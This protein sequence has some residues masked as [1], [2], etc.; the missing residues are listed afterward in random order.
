MNIDRRPLDRD[1]YRIDS[2]GG[3]PSPCL[4][5][6]QE[7]VESN[8]DLIRKELDSVHPARGIGCLR[9]HVKTHKSS[10]VTRMQL[11]A[12]ID[13]FKCT[14][15]EL[16]MLLDE[17]VDNLFVA[18]PP[19]PPL[20]SRIARAVSENDSLRIFSQ[21][22][23]VEHAIC[24]AAAADERSVE[25]NYL[26]DTDVGDHRTGLPPSEVYALLCA[27]R[28]DVRFTRLRFAGLHAYDGHNHSGDE[29]KRIACARESME[30]LAQVVGALKEGQ[31]PIEKVVVGGTPGF[32]HCLEALVARGDLDSEIEVSPGTFIYWDTCYDEMMPGRFH[33]A[34]LLLARVMDRP[35][36][37]RITLD[38]GHKR[39]G[40]DQGFVHRFSTPGLRVVKVSEEHTVLEHDR[41]CDL[42]IGDWVLIAPRHVCPTVNLW[43]RFFLVDR[44]GL[45]QH[46]ALAVTARNR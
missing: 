7:Q 14:P 22:S 11:A 10:W 36:R 37:N 31:I 6:F 41:S 3:L 29:R 40:I 24:L 16:D 9:P 39:W 32:L 44:T 12:G 15:N 17:G 1:L 43:E 5:V 13:R 8:L 28:E 21:V 23:C 18:Y 27:I 38:I 42:Q 19:L 45:P 30:S 33:L 2:L 25:I 26:I 34:A 4:V 35:V 20:A 46:E